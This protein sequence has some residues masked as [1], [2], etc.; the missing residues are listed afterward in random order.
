MEADVTRLTEVRSGTSFT[1]KRTGLTSLDSL[2]GGVVA[3]EAGGADRETG[4][5]FVEVHSLLTNG[6]FINVGRSSTNCALGVTRSTTVVAVEEPSILSLTVSTV[7]KFGTN[8]GITG[9]GTLVASGTNTGPV[10]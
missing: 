10:S 1:S 7:H 5:T 6:T 8:T 3:V 4:H 2:D 9:V